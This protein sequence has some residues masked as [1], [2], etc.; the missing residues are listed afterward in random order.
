MLLRVKWTQLIPEE[1]TL[2]GTILAKPGQMVALF[3]ES[4]TQ[5]PFIWMTEDEMVGWHHRLNERECEQTLGDGEGVGSLV[6]CS[7]G[8]PKSQT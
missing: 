2:T 8:A 4:L 5:K 3:I 6:R 7:H 1:Q